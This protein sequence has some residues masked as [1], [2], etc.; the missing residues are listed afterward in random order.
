M[1]FNEKVLEMHGGDSNTTVN[2]LMSLNC[3]IKN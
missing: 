2:V 1:R 3:T